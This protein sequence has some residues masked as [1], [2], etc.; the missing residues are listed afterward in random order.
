M[1]DKFATMQKAKI[2]KKDWKK[3][4]FVNMVS[5]YQH[6]LIKEGLEEIWGS[7]TGF[8]YK[9]G[10]SLDELL[11][12]IPPVE[13][14]PI[15]IPKPVT[16]EEPVASNFDSLGN[17]TYSENSYPEYDFDSFSSSDSQGQGPL[18]SDGSPKNN[19]M[20]SGPYDISFLNKY[21]R[22]LVPGSFVCTVSFVSIFG[23]TCLIFSLHLGAI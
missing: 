8:S 12:F 1:M 20:Y 15:V 11:N 19:G 21:A 17:L 14:A 2:S 23:S 5:L 3:Q 7:R 18:T 4:N 6:E 13:T 10:S 9:T 16:Y 22:I